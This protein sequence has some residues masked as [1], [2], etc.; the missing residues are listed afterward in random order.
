MSMLKKALN[1]KPK[2]V[3][4]KHVKKLPKCTEHIII[5]A[6]ARGGF[7]T[8]SRKLGGSTESSDYDYVVSREFFIE[9]RDDY[10]I[11][12]VEPSGKHNHKDAS[13]LYYEDSQ[14]TEYNLIVCKNE[15]MYNAWTVATKRYLKLV[16][17]DLEISRDVRVA[18]F[19]ALVE[20]NLKGES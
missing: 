8:G 16:N 5:D 11:P 17:T 4:D 13:S 10:G 20:D 1:T 19:H 14:G 6:I 7:L 12:W 2:K 3:E 18:I 9:L 15:K